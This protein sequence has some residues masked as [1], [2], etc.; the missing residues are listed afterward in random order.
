MIGRSP[1]FGVVN[2]GSERECEGEEY[3]EYNAKTLNKHDNF[4]CCLLPLTPLLTRAAVEFSQI[5]C[6]NMNVA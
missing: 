4:R 1:R 2:K 6:R 5:M 3:R